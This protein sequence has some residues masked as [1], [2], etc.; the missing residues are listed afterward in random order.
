MSA[1]IAEHRRSQP[2][3]TGFTIRDATDADVP[4]IVGIY[5]AAIAT[6]AAT[7]QLEPITFE[8]GE[9]WLKQHS[10]TGYPFWIA[11]TNERVAGWL[12]CKPFL[13]RCAYRG[14]VELSVYVDQ[15]FR[16]RGIARMLLE[17]AIARAPSFGISA[18]V[19]L[20]FAHNESSLQL[21]ERLGFTRWGLLPQIARVD[22]L[23][24]DL[25]IVGRNCAVRDGDS[26]EANRR[27]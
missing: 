15:D 16:C 1:L 21:F 13:P 10:H 8:D 3:A 19:G 23:E 14:T 9:D 11:E 18:M 5:N 17:Q 26:I 27:A 6:R 2:A 20:I 22:D 12:S 24:R 7:A 25:V 4:A